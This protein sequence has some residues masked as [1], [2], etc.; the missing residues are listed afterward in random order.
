MV[1]LL[2]SFVACITTLTSCKETPS[3]GQEAT[4]AYNLKKPLWVI[5]LPHVL[6]EIS[7]ITALNQSTIA[8]VQDEDGIVFM[9]DLDKKEI[10]TQRVFCGN[11][12]YEGI[13]LVDSSLFILRSDGAIFEIQDYTNPTS[14]VIPHATETLGSNNEGLCYDKINNRLLIARKSKLGKGK[15]NKKKRGIFSFDLKNRILVSDPVYEFDTDTIKKIALQEEIAL[16]EKTKKGE[17]LPHAILR[18][19]ASEIAVH[20]FSKQLYLLSSRDHLLFIID[21]NGNVGSIQQLDP[22]VFK[23]P[24]GLTFLPNGD[25]LIANEGQ[26]GKATLLRFAY[27]GAVSRN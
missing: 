6:R 19:A 13:T 4:G 22:K 12:D 8:C 9:Y 17:K 11:G 16:K 25:M 10:K 20:P 24:E 21:E 3:S 18:F 27:T 7:G 1:S 5:E 23:Q 14:S 26:G 15:M 2:V